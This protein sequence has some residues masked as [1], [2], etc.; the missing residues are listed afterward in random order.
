[1]PVT[2]TTAGHEAQ[3]WK[4]PRVSNS[5]QLFQQS[6]PRDFNRS[7]RL[8]QSSFTQNVFDD[9][10]ISGSEHGFVWA[11]YSAYSH[12]H[13][14]TLR[15]DDVWFS[16]LSQLRYY[17]PAHA[18]ELR[19]FF[20]SHEG[21]KKLE[22][23]ADGDIKTVDFGAL[24]LSMTQLVQENVNDPDL[25][26]W[27]MPNFSTTTQTDRVVASVL[28]M[29][30]L[31]KYFDYE[32][33]LDCGIPTVTLL[34]ERDDWEQM[35]CKLDPICRL[36]EEPTCFVSLLRPVLRRF[37][38]SFDNPTS[39]DIIDFWN[40]CA[41]KSGGSGTHYLSGWLTAFC[42]WDDEGR[43]LFGHGPRKEVSLGEWDGE[44][45]GCELDGIYYHRMDS[46]QIPAGV[47]SVPVNV[48]D[49][50]STEHSMVMLAGLPGIQAVSSGLDGSGP[51][52]SIRPL[53]G[54]WIYEKEGLAE[55]ERREE[56]AKVINEELK[57]MREMDNDKCDMKRMI[58]L[59]NRREELLTM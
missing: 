17:I 41:H 40:K 58:T 56:E 6:R 49:Y 31:Q 37:V 36:G 52:D 54:W 50:D 15:P 8:I 43:S 10:H 33:A 20:V 16:I 25:R 57:V 27:I 34:G 22:L 18:E 55:E 19:S 48:R 45:A 38:A 9:T 23:V 30:A 11:V 13:H 21:K 29:G 5:E 3:G 24:A 42:F 46:W 53:S 1:M 39:P 44:C 35:L 28:M 12:H 47:G 32:I 26:T 51:L 59:L 4:S 7:K 14:L 2:L